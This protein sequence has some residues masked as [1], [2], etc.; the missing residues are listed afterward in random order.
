[1]LRLASKGREL[2]LEKQVKRKE[3]LQTGKDSQ[4]ALSQLGWSSTEPRRVT[5]HRKQFLPLEGGPELR[6]FLRLVTWSQ[7]GFEEAAVQLIPG[8]MESVQGKPPGIGSQGLPTLKPRAVRSRGRFCLK[9]G[10]E[11]G[12]RLRRLKSSSILR[13]R[14]KL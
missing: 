11:K 12:R 2:E 1:M 13:W 3:N 9:E 5:R 7:K 10:I 4:A 14:L 6:P 8:A